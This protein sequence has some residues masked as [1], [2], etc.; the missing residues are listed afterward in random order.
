M[1][2]HSLKRDKSEAHS[3]AVSGANGTST[4]TESFAMCQG[5][6]GSVFSTAFFAASCTLSP[7]LAYLPRVFWS[8]MSPA[9]SMAWSTLSAF[10]DTRLLTLSRN[11]MGVTLQLFPQPSSLADDGTLNPPRHLNHG[12]PDN[13]DDQRNRRH[14][15]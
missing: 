9:F 10:C 6:C 2:S 3:H 8:T 14:P 13:A 11:P 1:V 7:W 5:V 12:G 4:E 15:E